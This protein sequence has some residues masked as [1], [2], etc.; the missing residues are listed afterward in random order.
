MS[1]RQAMQKRLLI[2]NIAHSVHNFHHQFSSFLNSNQI[3]L[4]N[5]QNVLD[6][7]GAL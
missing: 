4:D 2:Y 1:C 5:H 7:R 3:Q 6:T